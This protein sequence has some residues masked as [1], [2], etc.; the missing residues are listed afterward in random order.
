MWQGGNEYIRSRFVA[1]SSSSIS[2]FGDTNDTTVT[3]AE[4]EDNAN[5]RRGKT[6]TSI[7]TNN[8]NLTKL[9]LKGNSLSARIIDLVTCYLPNID[10]ILYEHPSVL[11]D[12]TKM[13]RISNYDYDEEEWHPVIDRVDDNGDAESDVEEEVE[14]EELNIEIDEE[15][16]ESNNEEE[17]DETVIRKKLIT[18]EN[19]GT[20]GNSLQWLSKIWKE[21]FRNCEVTKDD[22]LNTL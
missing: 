17:N 10:T 19:S 12:R 3:P 13:G 18:E 1:S 4:I 21:D 22:F 16:G 7:P 8:E 6:M 11:N 15:E 5:N 9:S 2:N 14:E 20:Q